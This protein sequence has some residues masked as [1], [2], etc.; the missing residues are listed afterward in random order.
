MRN[1]MIL[2]GA[3]AALAVA[4]ACGDDESGGVNSVALLANNNFVYYDTS[5]YFATASTLHLSLQSLGVAVTPFIA[6]D[7]ATIDSVLGVSQ[8]LFIPLND[9]ASFLPDSLSAGALAVIRNFVDSTGGLL[10]VTADPQGFVL[11]DSLWGFALGMGTP[12]QHYPLNGTPAAGTPFAGGPSEV[13]NNENMYPTDAS[14][15]PAGALTIYAAGTDAVFTVIPQGRGNVVLLG[16]DW[17]YAHPHG[18]QDGNWI[19]V[20]RRALR[21]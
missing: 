14:T 21:L 20:L 17:Y 1:R 10:F 18:A 6:V 7:S 2:L 13:W 5:V 11:L 9:A 12:A 4:A 15:H 19:E 8:A 16:W 3:T